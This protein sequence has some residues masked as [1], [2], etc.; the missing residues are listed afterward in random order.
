MKHISV[1][2][3]VSRLYAPWHVRVINKLLGR[4]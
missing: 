4:W 1:Q 2:E 3:Y